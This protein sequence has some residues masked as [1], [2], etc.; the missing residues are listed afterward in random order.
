MQMKTIKNTQKVTRIIMKPVAITKCII[1]SD[2]YRNDLEIEFYPAET[3]PDYMEIDDFI[4]NEV[5]G[6]E[7]NI[8]DVVDVIH[9]MLIDTYCPRKVVVR[10]RVTNSKTHFDVIVE[11]E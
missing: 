8:E 7:Y 11:K 10:D 6:K 1:G 2:W 4:F 3:Y 5:D 9:G